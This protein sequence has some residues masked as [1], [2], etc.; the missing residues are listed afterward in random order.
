VLEAHVAAKPSAR[1]ALG[2][3]GERRA[4]VEHLED[5]LGRRE[6][7][8]QHVVALAELAHGSSSIAT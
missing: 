3:A 8:L 1:R 2:A 4:R 7:R 6:G 5:A